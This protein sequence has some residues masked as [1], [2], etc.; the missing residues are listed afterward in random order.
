MEHDGPLK[1]IR[2]GFGPLGVGYAAVHRTDGGA[3]L[4]VVE[5]DTLGAAS[6]IDLES[7]GAFGDRLVGT[8]GLADAAVDAQSVIVVAMVAS[9]RV[10]TK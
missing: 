10:A 5:A 2:F 4:L 8:L 6:W 3:L 1:E 9:M 7:H